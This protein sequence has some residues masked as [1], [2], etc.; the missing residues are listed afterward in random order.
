MTHK[1]I[2]IIVLLILIALPLQLRGEVKWWGV[3][4]DL[5]SGV[6]IEGLNYN[7]QQLLITGNLGKLLVGNSRWT[8]IGL[9]LAKVFADADGDWGVSYLPL[10]VHL[11]LT[12][13]EGRRLLPYADLFAELSWIESVGR[14]AEYHTVLF[15]PL[16]NV[17]LGVTL[18]RS[19][20]GVPL[21]LKLGCYVEPGN[22]IRNWFPY[23][24]AGV[25]IE[26]LT[27][28]LRLAPMLFASMRLQD[29]D[30]DGVLE[31]GERAELILNLKNRG[32]GDASRI[33]LQVT[34]SGSKHVS[35]QT[36]QVELK[37]LKSGEETTVKFPI[38]TGESL[39][40]GE[41]SVRLS[42]R[43][44]GGDRI[45]LEFTPLIISTR[46]A[47]VQPVVKPKL[48][49]YLT[50]ALSLQDEGKDGILDAEEGGYLDVEVK[51]GGKGKATVELTATLPEGIEGLQIET[52]KSVGE[53]PPGGSRSVRFR[54]TTSAAIADSAFKV[55]VTARDRDW[56]IEA[57]DETLVVTRALIPPELNIASYRVIDDGSGFSAGDGDGRP[58][59]NETVQIN[60]RVRNEGAG[61]ARDVRV[62][63]KLSSDQV[64]PVY[65]ED[66]IGNVPPGGV[67][68]AK[69]AF[70]IKSGFRGDR[71]PISVLIS[72]RHPQFSKEQQIQL[73]F[74]G[75]APDDTSP[76]EI[77]VLQPAKS[78]ILVHSGLI[79]LE[80]VITDES[81][82]TSFE[83]LV[84]GRKVSLTGR[85]VTVVPKAT[86]SQIKLSQ[87]ITLKSGENTIL[88]RSRDE[89][90]NES[91]K[92][93]RATYVK[94]AE[95]KPPAV[96]QE[97]PPRIS[98]PEPESKPEPGYRLSAE[99]VYAVVVGISEYKDET[100]PDLSYASVD[101]RA[102][103]EVLTDRSKVGLKR[104]NV[105]L[106]LDSE[107]TLIGIR[108]AVWDWL[109]TRAK[110]DSTIIIFFAGHGGLDRDRLGTQSDGLMK[111]I[112]PHDARRDALYATAISTQDFMNMLNALASERVVMFFDS[113]YSGGMVQSPVRSVVA[114]G[115]RAGE[116]EANPFEALKGRGRIVI[117][118][119]KPN[120]P[121]LEHGSLKHGIFTYYLV[122]ALSGAADSDGDGYVTVLELYRYVSRHVSDKAIE[123][124]GRQEPMLIGDVAL[125]F[126]VSMNWE[127]VQ[128]RRQEAERERKIARVTSLYQ[129]GRISPEQFERA[130]REIR[131]GK[132]SRLLRDF[133][134]GRISLETFRETYGM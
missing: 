112:L 51:N 26:R 20:P 39:D 10:H 69:L 110:R 80:A 134:S 48:P 56:G 125:D 109:Y 15:K 41:L 78:P 38:S 98:P 93:I 86:G 127:L 68:D 118:A 91:A 58:E 83:V 74:A 92:L 99:N 12:R 25:G 132:E 122:E 18:Y 5:S 42:G 126:A 111:F 44:G 16:L 22:G 101:A 70:L 46:A 40:D 53:I 106:L 61:G 32:D 21:Q 52:A 105:R 114:K 4:A 49:P 36:K 107:A 7:W 72:E 103:Y 30:G 131:S 1:A 120:Q 108:E 94:G 121:S 28:L 66:R 6:S 9:S 79:P 87:T 73:T 81:G 11:L 67:S 50:L 133:L 116:V 55:R 47:P 17:G 88:V 95:A 3:S 113:C 77:Q 34:I 62:R 57:T 14:E 59:R 82:I 100:I 13:R 90:G 64:V 130:V 60:L 115:F 23:I 54:I 104:E 84:N 123:L 89:H 71:I 45:R 24:S 117:T 96:A 19:S 33:N 76:P 27:W 97:Q 31:A 129:E 35:P 119:S 29:E 43:Q 63:L 124:G 85:G 65:A 2:K 75:S 102:L 128:R 8:G 37:G